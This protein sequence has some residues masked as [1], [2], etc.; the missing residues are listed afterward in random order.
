METV[1][2]PEA[3][4]LAA[5]DQKFCEA[6]KAWFRIDFV[7]KMSRVLLA[8]PEFGRG[9]ARALL[10]RPRRFEG[11]VKAGA[12]YRFDQLLDRHVGRVEDDP[13]VLVTEAHLRPT[14]ALEPFQGSLDRD[15]SG[16]SRHPLDR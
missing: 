15:G 11:G 3:H 6:T 16:P 10:R 8:V 13:R 14:H 1:R 12:A 2:I 4:E 5:D 7:P 9:K